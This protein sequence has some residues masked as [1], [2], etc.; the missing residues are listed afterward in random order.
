MHTIL[1]EHVL[2]HAMTSKT[3]TRGW[4]GAA[5]YGSSFRSS[6]ALEACH[7]AAK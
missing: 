3:T 2:F 7:Q 5:K 1:S 4:G 6:S